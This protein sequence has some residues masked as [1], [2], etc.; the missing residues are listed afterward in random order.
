M[1]IG[2]VGMSIEFNFPKRF[3][4]CG[5]IVFGYLSIS[6]IAMCSELHVIAMHWWIFQQPK[7]ERPNKYGLKPIAILQKRYFPKDTLIA[8]V[9]TWN[10]M[11]AQN[12]V[13]TV[14]FGISVLILKNLIEH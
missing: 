6:I 11:H 3:R 8:Y 4:Q 2:S 10:E 12:D 9:Y 5:A 14:L 13:L 1:G 7:L